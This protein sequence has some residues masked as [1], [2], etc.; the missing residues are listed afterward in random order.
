IAAFYIIQSPQ[1]YHLFIDGDIAVIN[2]KHRIEEFLITDKDIIFYNRL[3]GFEIM[4]GSFIARLFYLNDLLCSKL[5]SNSCIHHDAAVGFKLATDNI[6]LHVS[7]K[8]KF[9]RK[10]YRYLDLM[11]KYATWSKHIKILPKGK[12]W[13]RDGW[14]TYSKWSDKDFMLHGWHEEYRPLQPLAQLYFFTKC[15]QYIRISSQ[16]WMLIS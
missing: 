6:I 8:L 2:P 10:N 9:L 15:L 3:W 7:F 14:L 4:A 13:S 5:G 11:K 1:I 12:S 16:T